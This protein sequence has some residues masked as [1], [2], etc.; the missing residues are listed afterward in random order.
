MNALQKFR[1][2]LLPG[3]VVLGAG[4]ALV[5]LPAAS[6]RAVATPG[7]AGG[8]ADAG[9]FV[10]ATPLPGAQG[11]RLVPAAS[12]NEARYRVREQLVGRDLPNDAVGATSAVTGEVVISADGTIDRV[13]SRFTVDLT[14]IR[15][16][17]DRRD[18]YVR[19]NT[20][21]T[22]QHPNAVFVPT[23]VDGLPDPLP[24]SGQLSFQLLG[25]LT[26][27]GATR[28]VT[29]TVTARA[30][31]NGYVGSAHTEF[32]FAYFGIPVPRVA[33]V[34]SVRESIRLEYDFHLVRGN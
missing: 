18:N 7:G 16:D 31:G 12:G 17:S 8:A 14:A 15:S 5:G 1:R 25:D 2:T 22:A 24:T 23:S 34:L 20:L 4:A 30:E 29:W 11:V 10:A 13:R 28:P 3:A 21:S 26:V 19:R 32:S 27:N 6:A 9:A 33:V